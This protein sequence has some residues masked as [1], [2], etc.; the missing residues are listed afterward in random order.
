MCRAA[1]NNVCFFPTS[2]TLHLVF[3]PGVPFLPGAEMGCALTLLI[4]LCRCDP[5]PPPPRPS[6]QASSQRLSVLADHCQVLPEYT[7]KRHRWEGVGRFDDGLQ[8]R[9]TTYT[10]ISPPLSFYYCVFG[11]RPRSG[12]SIST[13]TSTPTQPASRTTSTASLSLHRL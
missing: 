9:I 1:G 8:R 5:H 12:T 7:G 4:A 10:R 11:S 13:S 3:V 6:E 2:L